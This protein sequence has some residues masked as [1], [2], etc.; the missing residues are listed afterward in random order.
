MEFVVRCGNSRC[1]IL[2]GNNAG[3]LAADRPRLSIS[4]YPVALAYRKGELMRIVQRDHPAI[5]LVL[6]GSTEI[7]MFTVMG[8]GANATKKAIIG[9]GT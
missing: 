5:A 7:P 1:A 6:E 3:R 9:R 2:G 8:R 4:E